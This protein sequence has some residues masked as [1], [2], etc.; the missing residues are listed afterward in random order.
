MVWHQR[1]QKDLAHRWIRSQLEAVAAT[2]AG[3]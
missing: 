1:Y 2:A 3:G